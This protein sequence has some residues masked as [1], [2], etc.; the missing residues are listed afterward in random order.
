MIDAA[1]DMDNMLPGRAGAA[2]FRPQ[3]LRA[4]VGELQVKTVSPREIGGKLADNVLRHGF[5]SKYRNTNQII[6]RHCDKS[7]KYRYRM[8]VLFM[9]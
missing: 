5:S 7:L 9:I 1:V 8:S 6:K 4:L 2:F 3:R